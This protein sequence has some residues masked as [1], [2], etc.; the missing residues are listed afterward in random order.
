M[1]ESVLGKSVAANLSTGGTIDGDLTVTG[2]LGVAGDVSI[3]LT[4]VVSNSTIIDATGAEAFLV[5]ANSDGGDVLIVDTDNTRVGVGK[6]PTSLL[7]I[8]ADDNT[9]YQ[10]VIEQDSASTGDAALKFDLTGVRAWLV[11]LD[12]SDSDKFKIS[13]DANDLNDGN[14]ITIDTSLN[15]GLGTS[16]P[17]DILHLVSASD[18]GSTEVILDNSAAGD[19]TD[20][21]VGFRFRHNGGTAARI[22]VG[23]DE[24]FAN[25]AAR[26]GFISFRT[27]KDDT[28]TEKMD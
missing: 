15:I 1:I 6:T 4:S 7:H 20:E 27:S 5:R 16:S 10:T 12:N 18:G 24:N 14:A 21:L 8:Y 13:M 28:E 26:S 22:L 17:A 25:A 9:K 19:S 2:D 3:N 23:R 11:G